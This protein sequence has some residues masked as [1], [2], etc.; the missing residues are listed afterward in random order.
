MDSNTNK[1]IE[2]NASNSGDKPK[3]GHSS[4]TSSRTQ[5]DRINEELAKP[6]LTES[7][8]KALQAKKEQILKSL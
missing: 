7:A 1:R 4:N 3:Q 6:N 2:K 5:L 8:R